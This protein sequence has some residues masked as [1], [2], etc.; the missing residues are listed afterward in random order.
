MNTGTNRNQEVTNVVQQLFVTRMFCGHIL[1][2]TVVCE[3]HGLNRCLP[4][5]TPD[6]FVF[7]VDAISFFCKK[8][9][10]FWRKFLIFLRKFLIFLRKFQKYFGKKSMENHLK[11]STGGMQ[12]LKQEIFSIFGIFGGF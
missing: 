10:I 1:I 12:R 7:F 4:P 6:I 8:T 11:K 3:T 9:V 2:G 5:V